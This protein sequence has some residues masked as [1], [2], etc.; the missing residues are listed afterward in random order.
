[1]R[2]LVLVLA[3]LAGAQARDVSYW[4]QPR[5][6]GDVE[7]AEWALAA[8]ARASDGALKVHRAESQQRALL[9]I[10]WVNGA[11]GL[12]GQARPIAVDGERGATIFIRPDPEGLGPD[13]EATAKKDPLF[14]DAIVYLTV[15]HES[16]HGLG[17]PHTAKF[18][19]IMYSFGYGGDINEYFARYRRLI[20]TRADI[21][22]Q[23]GISEGDTE[24]LRRAIADR[25]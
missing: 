3:L 18:E 16:G 22:K 7:L 20:S 23:G 24:L 5:A 17:L 15:V 14:R 19:D 9:R 25:R 21:A 11:Q 12:Y 13:I 8:W 6:G 2:L 4:I 1:M 10:Y